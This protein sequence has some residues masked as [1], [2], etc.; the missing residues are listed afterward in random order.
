M[1][2]SLD[3]FST[4][5]LCVAALR[6][7][8]GWLNKPEAYY[9]KHIEHLIKNSINSS[10]GEI[11]FGHNHPPSFGHKESLAFNLAYYCGEGFCSRTPHR[12]GKAL[13]DGIEALFDVLIRESAIKLPT[14][15]A[16]DL[17]KKLVDK[18]QERPTPRIIL[19][20]HKVERPSRKMG[21]R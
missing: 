12:S 4:R 10:N 13:S 6:S 11:Q 15:S 16:K 3:E 21:G 18:H 1:L 14:D 19:S 9:I 20:D 7:T 5:D 2:N 17:T 8:Y